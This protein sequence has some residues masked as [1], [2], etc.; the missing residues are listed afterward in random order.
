MP[1]HVMDNY[2]QHNHWEDSPFSAITFF[3]E[4]RLTASSF[5]KNNVSAG[6]GLQLCVQPQNWR[7]N[8]LYLC[9][10]VTG[11]SSYTS[12]CRVLFYDSQGGGMFPYVGHPKNKYV[13]KKLKFYG[14][15]FIVKMRA[16]YSVFLNSE[17]LKPFNDVRIAVD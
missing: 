2:H 16:L 14:Y 10:S 12:R 9:P 11:W 15:I 1:P 8:S 13:V 5:R 6:Q 17:M 7:T 3:R 4:F